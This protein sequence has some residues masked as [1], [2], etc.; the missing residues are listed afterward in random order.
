[1]DVVVAL[2]IPIFVL[3]MGQHYSDYR[4]LR[5]AWSGGEITLRVGT[6]AISREDVVESGNG[7]VVGY[8]NRH[9]DGQSPALRKA[10]M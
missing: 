6:T 8:H 1:M 2:S 5:T 7:G 3:G 9:P 4:Y 10:F